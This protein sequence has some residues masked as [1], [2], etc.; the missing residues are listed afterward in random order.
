MIRTALMISS[1]GVAAGLA[2]PASNLLDG[3]RQ[4]LSAI[5]GQPD[6]GM[7]IIHIEHTPSLA[8]GGGTFSQTRCTLSWASFGSNVRTQHCAMPV[9][10]R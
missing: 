2:G 10:L 4:S 5:S 6:K 7:L 8:A 9:R 1:L 3:V